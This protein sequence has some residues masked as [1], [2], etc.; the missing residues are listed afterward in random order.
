M[1]SEDLKRLG[2]A[3]EEKI[4]HA[5]LTACEMKLVADLIRLYAH[6]A[7]QLERNGSPIPRITA[8]TIDD[9]LIEKAGGKVVRLRPGDV[10]PPIGGASC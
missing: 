9:A 2:R 5:P 3:V 1:L 6:D 7:E 8:S 4:E 10:T